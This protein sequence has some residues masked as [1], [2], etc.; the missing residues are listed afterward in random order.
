[1]SYVTARSNDHYA[2]Y[3]DWKLN[4]VRKRSSERNRRRHIFKT[5][6]H[7]INNRNNSVHN[8]GAQSKQ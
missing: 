1:M 2:W 7:R 8:M 4:A 6:E 3:A 5:N